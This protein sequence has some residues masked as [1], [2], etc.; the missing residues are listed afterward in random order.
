MSRR[1][2]VLLWV[3]L[4]VALAGVV[5]MACLALESGEPNRFEQLQFGMTR[6]EVSKAFGRGPDSEVHDAA[7][8]EK[9]EI[10]R[11]W[12]LD[13]SR[14]PERGYI[15]VQFD[16]DGRLSDKGLKRGKRESPLDRLRRWLGR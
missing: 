5:A 10:C 3:G 9:R 12:Y 11:I 2:R 6:D 7:G 14:S 1:K 8:D 16:A 15:T 13:K 4:L